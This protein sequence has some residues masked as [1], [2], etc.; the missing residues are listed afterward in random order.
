MATKRW[1]T[2]E[3]HGTLSEA[4]AGFGLRVPDSLAPGALEIEAPG[5]DHDTETILIPFENGEWIRVKGFH[6]EE[7]FDRGDDCQVEML[8][9]GTSPGD[10]R[11]GI[12]S[13]VED[14]CLLA[15]SL[16]WALSAQGWAVVGSMDGYF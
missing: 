6:T 1:H 10:S 8:A 14:V 3:M 12:Q 5:G 2:A 13:P 9:L 7:T 15:Q 4:I 11:G 16:A